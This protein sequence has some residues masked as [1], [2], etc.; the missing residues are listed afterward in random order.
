MKA[1]L[2]VSSTLSLFCAVAY[3]SVYEAYPVNKQ[4][5][6]IARVDEDF[7]FK[8]SN[9]TFKSTSDG[10]VQVSYN[11][12]EMPNWLSF[13]SGSLTFSGKPS[14]DFLEGEE[15]RYFNV[16]LEGTD[17]SD[18]SSSNTTC[19]L[20]ATKRSGISVASDFNLLNL[21]KNY[22]FTNGKDALKLSPRDIFNVTFERSYFEGLDNDTVLTYY[23]RST[24][25]NA[26]LPNW[27]FFDV[28]NLKFSGT[29]PVVNSQI[30]P[31]MD[32]SFSLIATDIDG[33]AAASIDFQIVV[34][35]HRLTTS[36]EN[37]LVIN[38][39]DS[40][41]FSYPIPLDYI[42]LDDTVISKS[43]L[44][45]I[46]LVNAPESIKISDNY[47]LTG[48]LPSDNETSSFQL[49]IYDKYE[50]VVYLNF[51]VESTQ[52]LFAIA[53]FPSVNVTRGEYFDYSLLPSQFTSFSETK[54]S[55]SFNSENNW[56]H[57]Q[58]S[59]LTFFG[60]VPNDFDSLSVEIVA[61]VG[62][63]K[64]SR[65]LKMIGIDGK[66]HSH[67][68]SSTSSS[69]SSS[70]TSSVTSTVDGKSTATATS[71][72]TV[73]PDAINKKKKSNNTV[74]IACG[75]AIPVAVILILLLLLLLWRRRRN[76]KK[77][78][79]KE[80]MA[81]SSPDPKNP[82]NEPND[83]GAENPF[84]D[85]NTLDS[86]DLSTEAK[87]LGTLNAMK[88][89]DVSNSSS[90]TF[91]DEKVGESIY[92]D[93]QMATSRDML[94]RD[95]ESSV[96][97][98]KYRTSSVYFQNA[99]SQRKSWRFSKG[100]MQDEDKTMRQ[101]YASLNTV[102]TQELLTSELKNNTTLPHDPR[103]SSLGLRDSVFWSKD[104]SSSPLKTVS[105]DSAR[106]A[107][108][109]IKSESAHSSMSSDDLI[110]MKQE[111]GRYKWVEND[112]PVRKHSTK[113]VG[114]VRQK[115]GV[116]IRNAN[117]FAGESPERI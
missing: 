115:V 38:I 82:A 42:Y 55:A 106:S 93:A 83:I 7:Q 86:D 44:G 56:L 109:K 12:Y 59:N 110:P 16:V 75:V 97:D 58:P 51:L 4:I 107:E 47:T 98:D 95:D 66:T 103:K 104:Q 6:P 71:T 49:S 21:L 96:F 65:T 29:A 25:Y 74:A 14:L 100:K 18:S 114:S 105:E 78:N 31:E 117:Q 15:T 67:T 19:Q 79:D 32:Y 40:G 48:K 88:L 54:V 11:A 94:V 27:V 36:I 108:E 64:E 101:S 63:K 91:S 60:E 112:R 102:S 90:I 73:T 34:G 113:R 84:S 85:E 92:E 72:S 62:S 89:D 35:A 70:S 8:I 87:R 3:A 10:S 26:P 116:D 76:E 33:F 77:N 68:S 13:D 23:G 43:D 28:N 5:P 24:Q 37:T 46:E 1:G 57:F 39:T 61:A 9:D 41:S 30:A 53:S 111:D 99:P 81:I 17:S 80:K 2:L 69:A 52:N 20:V 22:G 45:N 50:D